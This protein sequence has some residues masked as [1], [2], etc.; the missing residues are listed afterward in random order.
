MMRKSIAAAISVLALDGCLPTDEP[1][2][3]WRY[4]HTAI[5]Q[6]GCATAGCH[7]AL[8]A[9]AGLNLATSEGAYTILTGH[10]CGEP[11]RP[12]DPP[13]NYVT[14]FS[15]DYSQLM[16]QLRGQDSAGRSYRDVM[17]PDT[18]LPEA[19]IRLVGRWIDDGAAC[20]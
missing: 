11:V 7:S 12:Q 19:E 3:R 13:R 8:T 6:P 2:A 15:A 10:I 17:P 1:P 4:L 9:I 16:Y 5:I 14:P 20:D 18:A